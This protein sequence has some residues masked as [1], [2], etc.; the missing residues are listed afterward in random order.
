MGKSIKYLS[1]LFFL[2]IVFALAILTFNFKNIILPVNRDQLK[3][4][5]IPTK[6]SDWKTPYR[7]YANLKI[8]IFQTG[9]D[10]LDSHLT[11]RN[12]IWVP[13]LCFVIEKDGDL[14]VVD[15]GLNHRISDIGN[16][17]INFW[18][19]L[20]V[21]YKLEK[22]QDL[23]SQMRKCGLMP[24]KVKTVILTHLHPD[25]TGETNAFSNATVVV[26]KAEKVHAFDEGEMKGWTLSEYNHVNRWN[27]IDFS[28]GSPF[29]TFDRAIDLFG[30]QSIVLLDVAGHTI[31]DMA[32]FVCAP[33]GPMLLSDDTVAL[34]SDLDNMYAMPGQYDRKEYL[35]HLA[36]IKGFKVNVPGLRI[37]PSHQIMGV[38]NQKD[39][40]SH[41]KDEN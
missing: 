28:K 17:Y 27:E 13:V 5:K 2:A 23:P 35:R 39:I 38:K 8:H 20:F 36:M 10:K 22:G 19:R 32:V 25:H 12:P 21:E 3:I 15:T 41:L 31:G 11:G 26:S 16:K 33:G 1:G 14:I 34:M 30:D 18:S 29:A 40:I 6:I 9:W 4:P 37:F 24:E 7:G